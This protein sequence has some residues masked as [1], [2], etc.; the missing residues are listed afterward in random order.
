MLYKNAVRKNVVIFTGK[1]LCWSLIFN[2]NSSVLETPFQVF[3]SVI[4][5]KYSRT[6]VLKNI[7]ERLLERFPP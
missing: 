4:I 6:P 1:Y 5:A 2:E 3:F 7:C